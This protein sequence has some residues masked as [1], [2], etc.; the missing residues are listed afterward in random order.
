MF[1]SL[2]NF[3]PFLK[4]I[5]RNFYWTALDS[6]RLDILLFIPT[7]QSISQ[8]DSAFLCCCSPTSLYEHFHETGQRRYIQNLVERNWPFL[9]IERKR[10]GHE[11][12]RLP[13]ISVNFQLRIPPPQGTQQSA[14]KLSNNHG[15]PVPL[16][17]R[18]MYVATRFIKT[19]TVRSVRSEKIID[20][21]MGW[22]YRYRWS[23]NAYN[24]RNPREIFPP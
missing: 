23:E 3:E 14:V 22:S 5:P 20:P 4:K 2:D 13:I 12:A 10:N 7:N 15:G 19:A 9:S 18:V 17:R 1:Q 8:R 11:F 6:T 16:S 24:T 21:R